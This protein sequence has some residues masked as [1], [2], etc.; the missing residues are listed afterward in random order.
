MC[1]WG[2]SNFTPTQSGT[3]FRAD[4]LRT[5][6]AH[7]VSQRLATVEA[8]EPSDATAARASFRCR[9]S[10]LESVRRVPEHHI[11]SPIDFSDVGACV[12]A[13]PPDSSRTPV[14][15]IQDLDALSVEQLI[16][17]I[18][19]KTGAGVNLSFPG[20][21]VDDEDSIDVRLGDALSASDLARFEELASR[22]DDEVRDLLMR[23]R[24]L[25]VEVFLIMLRAS[26]QSERRWMLNTL[27][28]TPQWSKYR[29][30]QGMPDE[31]LFAVLE[32]D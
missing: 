26:P 27:S 2:V 29:D 12:R 31:Y 15:D 4:R 18:R 8:R 19:E 32:M 1:P 7:S 30:E 14:D 6:E 25:P 16:E 3:A 13:A 20:K 5:P 28:S 10:R 23:N 17:I 21:A 11:D 24:Q 9:W 22:D